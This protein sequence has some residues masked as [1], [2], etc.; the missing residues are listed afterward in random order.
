MTLVESWKD[1]LQLLKPA[2]CKQL[3]L[4]S[5]NAWYKG[6][7]NLLSMWWF[8]GLIGTYIGARIL[9]SSSLLSGIGLAG[10]LFA[11]IVAVRPSVAK[12]DLHYYLSY[13]LTYWYLMPLGLAFLA[14]L[15]PFC[16]IVFF[17]MVVAASFVF[18]GDGSCKTLIDSLW[19]ALVMITYNLPIFIFGYLFFWS[20]LIVLSSTASL[21][22]YGIGSFVKINYLLL[23]QTGKSIVAYWLVGISL[24]YAIS[25]FNT[26]SVKKLYEQ[27]DLFFPNR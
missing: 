27:Y 17:Y 8:I 23:I 12:K 20:V 16:Y 24:P 9:F 18:D 14:F 19:R 22:V 3:L 2:A 10:I 25:F 11:W 1:S 26:I 15:F 21:V 6:Y 5:A 4:I 7:A 13:A